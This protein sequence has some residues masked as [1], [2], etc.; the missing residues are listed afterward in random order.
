MKL[1]RTAVHASPAVAATK[2]KL[3]PA[4]GKK[5]AGAPVKKVL[6]HNGEDR[7]EKIRQQA[8]VLFMARNGVDGCDL[9]DWLRAEAMVDQ[10]LTQQTPAN[11]S[12][13]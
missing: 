5:A 12:M 10:F 4:A 2:A 7:L 11:R 8:Y 3:A 9:D 13:A 6:A 1:Q